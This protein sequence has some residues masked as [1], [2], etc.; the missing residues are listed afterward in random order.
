VRG[1]AET[2]GRGDQRE[3]DLVVRERRVS[4]VDEAERGRFET[5]APGRDHGVAESDLGLKA[6]AGTDA[7]RNPGGRRM[8][9]FDDRDLRVV[10]A[11]AR[12]RDGDVAPAGTAVV[13]HV[14]IARRLGEARTH[15]FEAAAMRAAARRIAQQIERP[16]SPRLRPDVILAVLGLGLSA[17]RVNPTPPSRSS[18]P[19][20]RRCASRRPRTI[21][22]SVARSLTPPDAFTPTLGPTAARISM[23]SARSR[24]LV[25]PVDVFT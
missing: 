20:W 11:H 9:Q 1:R 22:S 18:R 4:L 16:T 12:R 13:R 8:Q 23:T 19:R 24:R 15:G 21:F 2:R 6:A 25:D 7:E 10:A 17:T 14:L 3:H 5:D